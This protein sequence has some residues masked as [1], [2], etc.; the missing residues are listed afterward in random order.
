MKKIKLFVVA[1][2]CAISLCVPVAAQIPGMAQS[3]QQLPEELQATTDQIA[4]L[5]DTMRVKDQMSSLLDIMPNI[6]QQQM[7][8]QRETL[9]SRNLTPEQEEVVEKFL[10][11]RIEHSLTLY[12]IEEI[13]ADVG[14]IY[15]KYIS[16]EHADA[17]I[18]FYKTPVAQYLLD[19][20]PAMVQESLPLIM[21]RMEGV[22]RTFTEETAREAQSLFN[23]LFEKQK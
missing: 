21:S 22:V 12:P 16:R 18:T 15:K 7:Q 8:M 10:Q 17:L 2:F 1:F 14:T 6:I 20:Q 5:L 23:E 13:I 19:V 11:R 9:T 4:T 3:L